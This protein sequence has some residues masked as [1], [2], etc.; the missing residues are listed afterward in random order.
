MAFILTPVML[1]HVHYANPVEGPCEVVNTNN[2]RQVMLQSHRG[3]R[4][5]R[6]KLQASR[7]LKAFLI[8]CFVR[9]ARSLSCGWMSLLAT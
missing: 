5:V 9:I 8:G 3:L 6:L 4:R 1:C 2:G 7:M